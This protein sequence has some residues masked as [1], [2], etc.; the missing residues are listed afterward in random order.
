MKNIFAAF[1]FF[2]LTV[3]PFAHADDA[4]SGDGAGL[5]LLNRIDYSALLTTSGQPTE[6]ELG[7]G[8]LGRL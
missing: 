2:L 5:R 3:C 4:N 1:V 6:A 8:R 7:S